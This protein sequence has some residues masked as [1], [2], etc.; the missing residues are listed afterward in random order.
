MGLRKGPWKYKA[1][2]DKHRKGE[3]YNLHEETLEVVNK[4][5]MHPELVKKM[6]EEVD[7]IFRE[8]ANRPAL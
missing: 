6:Q 3:L 5:K 1:L 4:Y 7:R 2:D 8:S